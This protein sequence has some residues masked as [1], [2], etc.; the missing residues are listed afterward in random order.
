MSSNITLQSAAAFDPTDRAVVAE[1]AMLD[2]ASAH[3]SIEHA[4]VEIGD[5]ID[6][7]RIILPAKLWCRF[8][9]TRQFNLGRRGSPRRSAPCPGLTMQ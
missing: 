3:P 5:A 8:I 1:D 9:Y 7:F 6:V 4:K 2:Y